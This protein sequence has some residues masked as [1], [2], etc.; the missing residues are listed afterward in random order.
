MPAGALALDKVRFV[1]DPVALVLAETRAQAVDAVELVDVDYDD[2]PAVTDVEA[3]VADGAPLQFE[4]LGTN[5]AVR[6]QRQGPFRPVRAADHVVRVRMVNQRVAVAPIEGNAILVE[7]G[8]DSDRH[9][10]VTAWVSTQH[11]HYARDLL[12]DA[13]GLAKDDVRVVAPHVGG[14][15]GGKAGIGTD[16]AA[17]ALAAVRLGRPV[18]WVETRSEAMLS[19]HGRGQVQYAE[20]GLT[21]EGRIVGLRL[22][23][24]GDCGAYAGFGGALAVGPTYRMAQGVYDIPRAALR[25]GR[26]DDQHL[27]GR[28]LSWSR[29]ARGGGLHR[30]AHRPRC[31]ELGLAPE[32]LRRRN[33]IQPDAFPFKTKTGATYDIGDYDLALHRGAAHRRRGAGPAGAAPPHRARASAGSWASASRR[34]SRSPG[35][36]APEYGQVV[37][38][39]DGSAAVRSG[40]SAHGQGHATSLLDA[41]RRPARHPPRRH[42]LPAVRHRTRSRPAA[43]P[44]DRAPC[45][46]AAT[47]SARPPTS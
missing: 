40:T 5:V 29:P 41:R 28:R 37:V 25:R 30:A 12:A 9:G 6:R 38:N 32:E 22:R 16:H 36:A 43:A 13:L 4:G 44:A 33:F 10:R 42:H 14:A 20:L 1:G 2:L 39:A 18:K 46:S 31:R 27:P 15:F 34:T 17:V 45:S 8:R 35:S 3:A 11:P 19:M 26:R 21:S 23:M 24:L 47:R 7:P